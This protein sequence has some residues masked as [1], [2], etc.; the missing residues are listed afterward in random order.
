MMAVRPE[1]WILDE[2]FASGLDPQGLAVLKERARAAAAQGAS[3]LYTTQILEVAEKF[4]DTLLVLD[5]G[6]LRASHTKAEMAAMPPE[7]PDSLE[8]RLRQFREKP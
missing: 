4:C 2:P 1:F 8:A 5:Q 6:K 7:G 3:I